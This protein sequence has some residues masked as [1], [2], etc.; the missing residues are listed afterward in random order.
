MK[1]VIFF[2]AI[3]LAVVMIFLGVLYMIPHVPHPFIYSSRPS[4]VKTPHHIYAALSFLATVV[5]VVIA[6]LA[7][8]KAGANARIA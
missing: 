3:A 1:K 7:R 6:F 8:P 2:A 4:I 5:L